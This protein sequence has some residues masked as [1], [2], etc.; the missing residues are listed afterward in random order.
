MSCC[1]SQSQ[2]VGR[3]FSWRSVLVDLTTPRRCSRKCK[4]KKSCRDTGSV[5]L[6]ALA[7]DT[8]GSL[9]FFRAVT[10]THV[11]TIAKFRLEQGL[12]LHHYRH[13]HG[14]HILSR[15]RRTTTPQ[16]RHKPK[17][18]GHHLHQPVQWDLRVPG[19]WQLAAFAPKMGVTWRLAGKKWR[20]VGKP[21]RSQ[22]SLWRVLGALWLRAPPSGRWLPLLLRRRLVRCGSA[23]GTRGYYPC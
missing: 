8:A 19:G 22:C 5:V 9:S 1:S 15:A 16:R 18:Q 4:D 10:D 11:R 12:H 3:N 13:C 17:R 14:L 7:T 21:A 2:I 20:R 23:L 6:F